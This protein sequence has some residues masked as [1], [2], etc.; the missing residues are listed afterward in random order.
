MSG[1]TTTAYSNNCR[2]HVRIFSATDSEPRASMRP[3]T[4]S[5]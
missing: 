5:R 4:S 2:S 1:T 3:I